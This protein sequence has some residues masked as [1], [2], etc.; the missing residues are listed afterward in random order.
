[1]IEELRRFIRH[2]STI[3]IHFQ[4]GQRRQRQKARDVSLGGLCF[5]SQ[6]AVRE[7]ASIVLEIDV[8]QP[9]FRAEGIVRWCKREGQRFIIGVGFKDK[10]VRYA[11]RMV[12]QV[13]HI[14]AYRQRLEA[15]TGEAISSQQAAFRWISDNAGRFPQP[16]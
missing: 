12:E 11:V 9:A 16:E 1:M 8:C 10:A 2:P 4:L 15:E 14:E 3:P 5:S 6:E 7:G 13:C